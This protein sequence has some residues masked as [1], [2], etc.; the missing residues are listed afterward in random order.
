MSS[1]FTITIS[2][3]D[4]ASRTMDTITKHINKMNAPVRNFQRSFGRLVNASGLRRIATGLGGIAQA[5]IGAASSLLKVVEPLG[6]LT[7][8]ASIAG[9]YRLTTAWAQF[10][11]RLGFDAQRIGIMPDKLQALQG[12]AEEAGASAGSMTSGLRGLR[13]TM[14]DAVGGR[15]NQALLYFRQLGIN[16]G[17]MKHGVRDVTQVLPELADKIVA[18]K[19]PTLQARVATQLLGAAGEDL[20]PYLRLGSAG[21]RRYEADARRMGVTNQAGVTAAN[22]LRLSQARLGLATRGLAYSVAE[23]AG[24]PLQSLLDWFTDLIAT[25]REAIAAK[26]GQFVQQFADW[27]KSV[28]WKQVGNDILGI[29]DSVR[30][31]VEEFGGWKDIAKQVLVIG[32]ELWAA[33]V[34]FK[35]GQIALAIT[36]V[37]LAYKAL[38]TAKLAAAAADAASG[39]GAAAG[40]G[41]W[42]GTLGAVGGFG[43]SALRL[44]GLGWAGWEVLH[45]SHTTKND[46]LIR[47]APLPKDI[48]AAARAAATRNGIDPAR[49]IAQLQT[50]GGGYSNV[51]GAGAFGPAQLMPGTARGLGVADSTASPN[52]SWQANVEAGAR[53]YRQLLDRFHGNNDAALAAYND[54]PNKDAVKRY[55]DTGDWT[56]LPSE[57]RRYVSSIDSLTGHTADPSRHLTISL[58]VSQAAGNPNGTQVRV[59]GTRMADG[60]PGPRVAHAMPGG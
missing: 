27:V 1:G 52:Y 17:D 45:P 51:S 31:T 50:E 48:A 34:V 8:V 38:R 15:N 39:A 54:G 44:G 7:S 58:E 28:N 55:A 9:L 20:L 13:D 56:G 18:I 21:M 33:S 30:R 49:Y 23:V 40:A 25:N 35:I 29:A 24:P 16:I 6:I 36:Q 57:T 12:A 32:A 19:D 3:V 4:R 46:T 14:V 26:V 37:T 41:G 42:L 2:A 22:N 60:Q 5:G 10:G 59:T 53:Y 43:A 11:A 47:G